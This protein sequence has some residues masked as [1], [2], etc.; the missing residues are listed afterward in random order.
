[1]WK[2]VLKNGC[3]NLKLEANKYHVVV[4]QDLLIYGE[5]LKHC[6]SVESV[7]KEG[8]TPLNIA[9]VDG[10]MEVLRELLKH[11]A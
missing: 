11:G 9:A 6:V 2:S 8:W 1:L 3:T 7:I 4:V 10:H 5:L